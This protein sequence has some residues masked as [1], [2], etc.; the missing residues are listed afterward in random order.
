MTAGHRPSPEEFYTQCLTSIRV[1][2]DAA[3]RF[4]QQGD[5]VSALAAAWGAD[6]Y[7]VQAVLWERV[8]VAAPVPHRQY[9]RA[10]DALFAGHRG[11]AEPAAETQATCGDTLR[12]SRARL[13]SDFD[14]E[15]A[16]AIRDLT[17]DLAYLD[18]LP[19]PT[20]DDLSAATAARCQGWAPAQ[21]ATRRRQESADAMANAQG[22]R[23]R[24]ETRAAI[25]AAYDADILGLEAYLVESALSA[26]DESLMSV[27]VRW[28]L[29]V[30]GVAQLTA[31]PE[32]F[33]AAVTAIREAMAASLP[34]AEAERLRRSLAEV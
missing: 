28:E 21:F 20:E 6:V 30:A 2:D 10:A 27:V 19:V 16:S 23:V 11:V 31:L 5:V 3:R 25:E 14:P 34:E 8:L 12:L 15:A 24:G 22:L 26:G 18:A 9:F 32:G 13:L 7:A 33:V 17:P 4:A 29:A 1:L